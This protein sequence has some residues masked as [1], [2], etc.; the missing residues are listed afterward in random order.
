MLQHAVV[1]RFISSDE[2][3]SAWVFENA[4]V[5]FG[6]D[7]VLSQA[8]I[9]G[10]LALDTII[11]FLLIRDIDI[12]ILPVIANAEMLLVASIS[13]VKQSDIWRLALNF[14]PHCFFV[15][16]ILVDGRYE[17]IAETLGQ[18]NLGLV[19]VAGK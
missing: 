10:L 9:K 8:A 5:A 16:D 7:V 4:G 18:R 1:I 14:K 15:G 3:Q 6:V 17:F 11:Q 12:A 2:N 13:K 19:F